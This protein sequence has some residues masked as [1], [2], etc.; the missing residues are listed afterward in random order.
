MSLDRTGEGG[1]ICQER[2]ILEAVGKRGVKSPR[3]IPAKNAGFA[4]RGR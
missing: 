1:P 4:A 3:P 2:C